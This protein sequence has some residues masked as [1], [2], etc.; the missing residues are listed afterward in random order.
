MANITDPQD[1]TN[2]Y[3]SSV[4]FSATWLQS[5]ISE[6]ELI[7]SGRLGDLSDWIAADPTLWAQRT[8][9]IKT[10]VGRMVRRVI[11]NP[12]GFQSE[13]DGDYSYSRGRSTGE[14]GDVY[15]S[16]ADWSMLGFSSR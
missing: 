15:A 6:A 2:G 8:K 4:P 3:E 7:L 11:R 14:P 5:K 1:V 13:A 9:K 10:V 16:P 12:E